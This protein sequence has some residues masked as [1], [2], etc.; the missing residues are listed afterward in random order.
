MSSTA[1]YDDDLPTNADRDWVRDF[2]RLMRWLR[3]HGYSDLARGWQVEQVQHLDAVPS[4]EAESEALDAALTHLYFLFNDPPERLSAA[5]R[6][7]F[8]MLNRTAIQSARMK[9]WIRIPD[10]QANMNAA[11]RAAAEKLAAWK[12]DSFSLP[13]QHEEWAPAGKAVEF[14]QSRGF[15]MTLPRLSTLIQHKTVRGRDRELPG[16]H[17]KE[18][19]LNSL[20]E[21]LER[22]Q[23]GPKSRKGDTAHGKEP[24]PEEQ[25][26]LDEAIQAAR[27]SK[28]QERPAD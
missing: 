11:V 5:E 24:S 7:E 25:K 21:F 23:G 1:D 16:S 28:R 22:T 2:C 12:A 15:R 20:A 19:E 26:Q 18:V 3:S 6:R 4:L 13:I 9:R 14:V 8:R 10:A 27:A 17:Q